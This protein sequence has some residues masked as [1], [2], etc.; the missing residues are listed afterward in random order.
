MVMRLKKINHFV[1]GTVYQAVFLRDAPRPTTCEQIP[2]LLG[3]AW[4][5]KWI[6]HYRFHQIQY[7]DCGAPVRLDPISKVLTELRMEDGDSLTFPFHRASLA[8]I[9][10]RLRAS[11]SLARLDALY[12]QER[13]GQTERRGRRRPPIPG[14]RDCAAIRAP[15]NRLPG[16]HLPPSLETLQKARCG[17]FLLLPCCGRQFYPACPA[18]SD[19]FRFRP[20]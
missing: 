15:S 14:R 2:E 6:A 12:I 8:A 16:W 10:L 7:S 9:Q 20:A 19:Q 3:L 5:L 4:A 11:L 1:A 17:W 18:S 13:R